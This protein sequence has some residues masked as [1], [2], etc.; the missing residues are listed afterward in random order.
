METDAEVDVEAEAEIE[1]ETEVEEEKPVENTR[2][3]GEKKKRTR[4]WRRRT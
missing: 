2:N 4:R 1:A 3:G